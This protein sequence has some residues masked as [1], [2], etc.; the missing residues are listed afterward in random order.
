MENLG[1]AIKHHFAKRGEDAPFV[2]RANGEIQWFIEEPPIEVLQKW[3]DEYEQEKLIIEQ[4]ELCVKILKETDHK[5]SRHTK[6]P[7]DVPEWEAYREA[8]WQI[9]ESEVLQ[10][11][12][13]KP[14]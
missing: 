2:K 1:S 12:P 11:I 6:Y 9:Q 8:I 4:R 13:S 10:E 7:N 3:C 5:V 14:F